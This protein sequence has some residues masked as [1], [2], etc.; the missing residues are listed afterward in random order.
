MPKVLTLILCLCSFVVYQTTIYNL[1]FIG[2]FEKP[3]NWQNINL[4]PKWYSY[5]NLR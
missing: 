1:L 5:I 4:S 3:Y 2:K